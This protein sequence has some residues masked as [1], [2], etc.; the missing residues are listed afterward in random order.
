MAK[1]ESNAREMKKRE[2]RRKHSRPE[3]VPFVDARKT[4][5]VREVE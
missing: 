3:A 4:T 5:V 1:F 2:N